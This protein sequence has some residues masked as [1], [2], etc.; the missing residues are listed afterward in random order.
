MFYK[1]SKRK[2]GS[3]TPLFPARVSAGVGKDAFGMELT[4][5]KIN[6]RLKNLG[7]HRLAESVAVLNSNIA[8]AYIFLVLGA[9]SRPPRQDDR[10]LSSRTGLTRHE[11][12][13]LL[14]VMTSY[15][16]IDSQR[17]LTDQG[18]G[19]LAHAKSRLSLARNAM[20]VVRWVDEPYYPKSLRQPI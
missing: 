10:L 6:T 9:L 11:L 19:Q 7:H 12:A 2:E 1:A 14:R 13:E 20:K 4:T 8:T 5:E 3:W 18:A 16:W 17:R 15:G